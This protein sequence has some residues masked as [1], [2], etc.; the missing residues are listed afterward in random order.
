MVGPGKTTL[1]HA[2]LLGILLPFPPCLGKTGIVVIA[3]K[4]TQLENLT[5]KEVKDLFMG[6]SRFLPNGTRISLSD[7]PR[8]SGIR[9]EF[10]LKLTGLENIEVVRHW[11]KLLFMGKGTPP[12]TVAGGDPNVKAWVIARANSIGYVYAESVDDSVKV[13]LTLPTSE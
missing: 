1:I 3:R 7:Q 12:E 5:A 13:L 4:D 6:D 11:A 10:Y 2:L 9:S 8:N